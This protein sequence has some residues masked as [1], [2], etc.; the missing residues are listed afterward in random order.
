MWSTAGET[1]LNTRFMLV[2]LSINA[3]VGDFCSDTVSRSGVYCAV[4]NALEQC[5][6]ER[7]VDIF[8]AVKAIRSQKPGAVTSAV[9]EHLL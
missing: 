2:T 9:R 8:Q 3:V 5:K 6:V 4:S 7:V 1:S